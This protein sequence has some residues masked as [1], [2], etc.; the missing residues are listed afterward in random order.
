[1][2]GFRRLDGQRRWG[3]GERDFNETLDRLARAGDVELKAVQKS[4]A[5]PCLNENDRG[6]RINTLPRPNDFGLSC[7]SGH[8]DARQASSDIRGSAEVRSCYGRS[9]AP[10][11]RRQQRLQ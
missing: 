2:L 8:S 6:E 10:Q 4:K 9:P 5:Q 11:L 3:L 1:M 7:V